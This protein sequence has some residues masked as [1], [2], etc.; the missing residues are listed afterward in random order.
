MNRKHWQHKI[1]SG[2]VV[3]V[4]TA[5]KTTKA[6]EWRARWQQMDRGEEPE[7]SA[8]NDGFQDEVATGSGE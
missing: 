4:C 6:A 1:I 2:L 8:A 3:T 5:S 7:P